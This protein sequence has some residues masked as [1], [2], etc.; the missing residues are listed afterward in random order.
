M[1]QIADDVHAR[2]RKLIGPH[3]HLPETLQR[4]MVSM[5]MVAIPA[6]LEILQDGT[7]ALTEATGGGFAPIHAARLLGELRADEAIEPM[8]RVLADSDSLDILYG[9]LMHSMIQIGPPVTEPALRAAAAD[10]DPE[11][12]DCLAEVLSRIGTRDERILELLLN[13]LRRNPECAAGNLADYGD[14]RAIPH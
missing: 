10:V 6:L 2:V 4:D 13:Q 8:L 9:Q 5:G 1:S 14:P 11:L 3:Q 12:Q 7:L